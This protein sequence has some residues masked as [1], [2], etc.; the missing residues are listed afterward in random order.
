MDTL[1]IYNLLN[2]NKK[3]NY[4]EF[5]RKYEY[6]KKFR[7][8]LKPQKIYLSD[9]N[10]F[11][12]IFKFKI[13]PDIVKDVGGEVLCYKVPRKLIRKSKSLTRLKRRMNLLNK[14]KFG[15]DYYHF[16]FSI[17]FRRKNSSNES[18]KLDENILNNLHLDEYK[19]VQ[20]IISL[21]NWNNNIGATAINNKPLNE[22]P[23][24]HAIRLY[25]CRKN[26]HDMIDF[27]NIGPITTAIGKEFSINDLNYFKSSKI[28]NNNDV[29]NGFIFD[30][31][32]YPHMGGVWVNE[33][34]ISL[35]VQSYGII[36]GRL[37]LF[38]CFFSLIKFSIFR[39]FINLKDMF[40]KS[41]ITNKRKKTKS[42]P[43]K[44]DLRRK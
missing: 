3:I 37:Y 27:E 42:S 41:F 12:D 16:S 4:F 22:N 29:G 30:G 13:K 34:R 10:N 8:T 32:H 38:K 11:L 35:H 19:G 23:F 6:S 28:S 20:S 17:R 43:I 7:N 18:S 15:F 24:L 5:F 2:S 25:N 33:D 1:K 44:R 36:F 14:E 31:F 9:F 40:K 21:N 26:Q 39:T